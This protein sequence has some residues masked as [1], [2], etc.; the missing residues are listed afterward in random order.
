MNTKNLCPLC[1]GEKEP[2]STTFTADLK[3]GVLVVRNVPAM[4]CSMCGEDW[5][6]DQ[7]AAMLERL[8]E[9]AKKRHMQ[10]EVVSIDSAAQMSG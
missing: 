5:I 9:D 7:T 2:G 3:S 4:V 10:V 1:G 8:V 6:E